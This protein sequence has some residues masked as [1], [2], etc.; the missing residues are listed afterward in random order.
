MA[1]Q[2]EKLI[3]SGSFNLFVCLIKLE[4]MVHLAFFLML[5]PEFFTILEMIFW[6]CTQHSMHCSTVDLVSLKPFTLPLSGAF[7]VL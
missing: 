7:P 1:F 4:I 3:S 6:Y 5:F 2:W